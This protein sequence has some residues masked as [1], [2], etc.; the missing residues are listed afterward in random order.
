MNWRFTP[1]GD[2]WSSHE[3]AVLVPRMRTAFHCGSSQM[4][5]AGCGIACYGIR[6]QLDD[7]MTG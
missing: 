3:G 6:C 5:C 4:R 1:H 7:E 2:E